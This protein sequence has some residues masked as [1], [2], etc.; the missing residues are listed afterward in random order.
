MND[1]MLS[2]FKAVQPSVLSLRRFEKQVTSETQLKC[3]KDDSN[4][5][6]KTS[7]KGMGVIT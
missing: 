2:I 5:K 3:I 4:T 7:T 6:Q 1:K